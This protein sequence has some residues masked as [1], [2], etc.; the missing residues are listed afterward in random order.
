MSEPWASSQHEF[1]AR[2]RHDLRTP[3]NQIIGYS[4]M[5]QEDAA[6]K[7]Q[8]EMLPDL[9]KIHDA[10]K[11]LLAII[12]D[13]LTPSQMEGVD[14][15]SGSKLYAATRGAL[16]AMTEKG[17]ASDGAP[18]TGKGHLLLVDDDAT[19][20]DLFVRRLEKQGYTVSTAENGRLALEKLHKGHYDLVLLDILMPEMNGYEA[21]QVMKSDDHLRHIPVIMISALDE[22]ESVI[23][24][25]EGGAEDY[26]SKPFDP[27]LLRARIGAC[28]EKKMLRDHERET[29]KKLEIEQEKSE[30]LLLNVLPK[31][32]AERLKLHE[33]TIADNFAGVTVLFAD[34]AN[35]TQLSTRLSPS[36]LVG[37][38]NKIFTVF[39]H[40]TSKRGLEKIKTIG[41]NYM[42]V[43]GLPIAREDHAE[44]VAD[45]A[46][47]MRS[48]I[49][50]FQSAD[51]EPLTMRIGIN[52][53]PVVAG[54]IGSSKF[55]YDLWGDTVNVASRMESNAPLGAIQVSSATYELL[56][57]TFD[58]ED[59]GNIEVKGKGEM[60]VY[61]LKGRR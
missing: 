10:A 41:D 21:L 40:I 33:K 11:N 47:E 49:R 54:V 8:K 30:R 6:E 9:G 26:L 28:L 38:L 53:G 20:R 2:L 29:L 44:V 25:I 58:L 7:G 36:E 31:P 15:R 18:G 5:L 19:N 48:A 27:V 24:C 12:H 16:G 55:I 57:D 39:D 60:R 13:N 3:L 34:I 14:A 61:V 22:M 4:E 59:R 50:N 43:G 17:C 35:F 56:K 1:L 51:G 37:M 46:I 45:L 52:S 42:V 23:R 32:I